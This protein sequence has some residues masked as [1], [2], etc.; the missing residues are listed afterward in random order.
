MNLNDLN[1]FFG[2]DLSISSAG[3]VAQAASLTRSQQRVLRRLLTNPGDYVFHPDYGAGLGQYIGQTLNI[4]AI[5]AVIRSQI[6]L[7]DSVLR[8]PE[9]AIT[10]AVISGGLSV[11]IQYTES[12]SGVSSVLSFDVSK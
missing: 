8:T 10:V 11:H 7:E 12:D 5:T 4:P 1:H 9:P 6:F 3:D 2:G